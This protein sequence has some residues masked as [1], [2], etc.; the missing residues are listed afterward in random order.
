[1]DFKPDRVRLAES[2]VAYHVGGSG[3]DIVYFHPAAGLRF[4]APLQRLARRF[5]VWA[6]IVPGF[7]GTAL[8]AA[9]GSMPDVG[10]PFATPA[11]S[12]L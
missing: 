2:E 6:P 7:D 5:R 11:N 1:M 8:V 4:T 10:R 12:R 3:G 9:V